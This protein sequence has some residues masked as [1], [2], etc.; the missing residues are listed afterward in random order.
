MSNIPTTDL[1]AG[2]EPATLDNRHTPT[3]MAVPS[4]SRGF[5]W[6]LAGNLVY[7]ASQG[8]VVV[9]LAKLGNATMVGQ[10]ALAVAIT[11]PIMLFAGCA[12][13]TVQATD[14]GGDFSFADYLGFRLLSVAAALAV[15]VI[16]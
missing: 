11:S 5:A 14:T 9:L 15:I 8:G 1:V 3:P 2:D 13:R 4:L 12:L 7:S 16:L 6:T 10:F